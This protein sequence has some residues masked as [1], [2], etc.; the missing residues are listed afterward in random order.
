[1][2]FLVS[3]WI[4]IGFYSLYNCFEAYFDF[5]ERTFTFCFKEA[6]T[7]LEQKFNFEENII[8]NKKLEEYPLLFLQPSTIITLVIDNNF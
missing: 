3:T 6:M 4:M 5:Q 2:I 8:K 1:M 7:N